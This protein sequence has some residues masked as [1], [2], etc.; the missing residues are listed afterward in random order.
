MS[1]PAF[2]P[3]HKLN[4]TAVRDTFCTACR[5]KIPQGERIAMF[6][7]RALSSHEACAAGTMYPMRRWCAQCAAVAEVAS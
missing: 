1:A 2:T 6:R 7:E 4:A 5:R 3:G